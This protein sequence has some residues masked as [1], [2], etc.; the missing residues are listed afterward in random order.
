[1]LCVNDYYYYYYYYY[2][3]DDSYQVVPC[4]GVRDEAD[5]KGSSGSWASRMRLHEL[6][7]L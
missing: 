5:Q 2:Y 4:V 3:S 1:M 6:Q 7:P